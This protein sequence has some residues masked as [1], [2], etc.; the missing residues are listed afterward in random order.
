M[1][2][3][4][5]ARYYNAPCPQAPIIY[6]DT[7]RCVCI[8]L[9]ISPSPPPSSPSPS[10]CTK[11]SRGDVLINVQD[12]PLS[13]NDATRT[14]DCED[15]F[16]MTREPTLLLCGINEIMLIATGGVSQ[17]RL[18]ACPMSK[19]IAKDRRCKQKTRTRYANWDCPNMDTNAKTVFPRTRRS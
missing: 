17:L 2:R 7:C 14:S 3:G 19:V 16:R 5:Y 8:S 4:H 12:E 18:S 1:L 9:S 15:H 10:V 11:A 6:S 13:S